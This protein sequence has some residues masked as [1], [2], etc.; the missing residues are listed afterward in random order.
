MQQ[1]KLFVAAE[2]FLSVNISLA[3]RPKIHRPRR[4]DIKKGEELKVIVIVV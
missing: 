3:T 1:L 4:V 2:E